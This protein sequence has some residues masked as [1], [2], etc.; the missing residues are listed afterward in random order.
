MKKKVLRRFLQLFVICLILVLS[1]EAYLEFYYYRDKTDW[2]FPLLPESGFVIRRDRWGRGDFGA[3]RNGGRRHQG[4][5]LLAKEGSGVVAV[6]S[7]RA[8][9]GE[10]PHGMGKFVSVTHRDGIRTIYGHLSA[11]YVKDRSRVRQ[12]Q[13]IGTVGKTGNASEEGVLPHLHFEMRQGAKVLNP[14]PILSVRVQSPRDTT[15]LFNQY[16]K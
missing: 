3:K 2:L 11:I 15:G 7:G 5:D 8:R 9:V 6:R 12:G 10:G 1:Y 16:G 14:T 4:V 13:V